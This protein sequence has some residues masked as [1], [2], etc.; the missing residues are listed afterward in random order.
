MHIH[1]QCHSVGTAFLHYMVVQLH[2]V[3]GQHDR[4]PGAAHA[5]RTDDSGQ[6]HTLSH[7]RMGRCTLSHARLR[8]PRPGPAG[9]R[10]GCLSYGRNASGTTVS[11]RTRSRGNAVAIRQDAACRPADAAGRMHQRMQHYHIRC[12]NAGLSCG[13][14]THTGRDRALFLFFFRFSNRQPEKSKF[15]I[16]P[17]G[18]VCGRTPLPRTLACIYILPPHHTGTPPGT[19]RR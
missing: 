2:A 8:P 18:G 4:R 9:Q 10:T 1:A 3:D 11:A 17:P 7:A 14:I 6:L 19:E 12:S 15:Q 16:A 13:Y 5:R